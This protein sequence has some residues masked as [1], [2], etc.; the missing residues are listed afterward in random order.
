MGIAVIVLIKPSIVLV[1]YKFDFKQWN[2]HY[3]YIKD[4]VT[5]EKDQSKTKNATISVNNCVYSNFQFTQA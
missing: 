5:Y 2:L 4:W 3:T 1:Q